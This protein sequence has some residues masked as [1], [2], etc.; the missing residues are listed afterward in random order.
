MKRNK[1]VLVNFDGETMAKLEQIAE[2][3]RISVSALCF[4]ILFD[5][6]DSLHARIMSREAIRYDFDTGFDVITI[7]DN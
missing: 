2:H 7:K 1:K 3:E 4:N 5:N 6:I